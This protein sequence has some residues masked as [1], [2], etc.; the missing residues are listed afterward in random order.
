MRR[1][2]I[3]RVAPRVTMLAGSVL[4]LLNGGCML[5]D[6]DMTELANL[7]LEALLSSSGTAS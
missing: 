1:F 7:M 2:W 5:E 3:R 6:V 4:L